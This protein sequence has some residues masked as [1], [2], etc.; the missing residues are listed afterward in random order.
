MVDPASALTE[1]TLPGIAHVARGKVREIFEVDGALLIVTTDR[2]SAFDVVLPTGIPGKGVVLTQL[3]LFWFRLLE[4]V[5]PNHVLAS[6]IDEYPVELRG[7]RDA[8]RSDGSLRRD[9]EE[10]KRSIVARGLTNASEFTQAKHD[11]IVAALRR[12]GLR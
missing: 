2:L 5:A 8:L 9:Y 1:C 3:S 11:F 10:L 6:E 7:F 12:L 4:E